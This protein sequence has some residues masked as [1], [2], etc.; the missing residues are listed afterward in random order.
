MWW[1]SLLVSPKLQTVMWPFPFP[2]YY[3]KLKTCW[4]LYSM[5]CFS[6]SRIRQSL[7]WH[8]WNYSSVLPPQWWGCPLSNFWGEDFCR[9]LPLSGGALQDHQAPQGLFHGSG[10]RGAASKNEPTERTTVQVDPTFFFFMWVRERER[11]KT[12]YMSCNT[13]SV[14]KKPPRQHELL[15]CNNL[16]KYCYDVQY[17]NVHVINATT[18]LKM[19]WCHQCKCE[20]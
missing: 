16:G 11:K 12:E 2:I 13:F 3:L 8:E 10:R 14:L 15:D 4:L 20:P 1:T 17:N 7:S 18:P 19:F 6:D 9:H 5:H